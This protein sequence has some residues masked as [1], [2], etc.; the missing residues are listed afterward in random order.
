MAAFIIV[1]LINAIVTI[2]LMCRY[3]GFTQ[4]GVNERAK[5]NGLVNFM[6]DFS[7]I[8]KR[9]VPELALWEKYLVYATVFGVADKVIKQLKVYFPEMTDEE[10]LISHYTYMHFVSNSNMNFIR[11][12]DSSIGS[13]TNYASESGVGGGFSSGGGGGFGGGGGGGR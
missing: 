4:K 1:A 6:K 11:S 9:E 12:I 8:D 2:P 10:Y 3:N 7:L 13:V 5:W